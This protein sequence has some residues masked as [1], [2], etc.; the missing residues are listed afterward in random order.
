M[1][2]TVRA[3]EQNE[4]ITVDEGY[5]FT[6]FTMEG[7]LQRE[8]LNLDSDSDLSVED[9]DGEDSQEEQK[10]NGHCFSR[11][12]PHARPP[13]QKVVAKKQSSPRHPPRMMSIAHRL[14]HDLP[15]PRHSVAEDILQS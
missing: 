11:K 10:Q 15:M 3:R 9:D 13:K 5:L 2:L 14:A 6:R 8:H 7:G 4:T 1:G 12:K